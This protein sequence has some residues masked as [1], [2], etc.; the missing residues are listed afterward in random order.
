[1]IAKHWPDWFLAKVGGAWPSTYVAL[2]VETTGFRK[3][4]EPGKRADIITE[5]GYVEVENNAPVNRATVVVDWTRD[6]AVDQKW[7]RQRLLDRDG[8]IAADGGVATDSYADLAAKG[9]PAKDVFRETLAWLES[10]AADRVPVVMHNGYGFDEN[11]LSRMFQAY[12]G[13]AD[14]SFGPDW[15]IDSQSLENA[16]EVWDRSPDRRFKLAPEP[17]DTLRSYCLRVGR[18]RP[19]VGSVKSNLGEHCRIKYAFEQA[20]VNARTMH[21][22][23]AD[24]FCCHLMMQ[25]WAEVMARPASSEP[26]AA[27]APPAAV[28]ARPAGGPVRYRGQRKT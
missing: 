8:Q 7:L 20:G 28:P 16:N 21:G 12:A 17:N 19:S 27:P 25:N 13:A 24:A 11:F 1:M 2:D 18:V 3:N 5:I 6:P 14:W 23:E 9:R 10:K 22:A 4:D 15:L 26:V